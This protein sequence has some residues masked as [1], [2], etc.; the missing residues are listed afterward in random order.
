ML[1]STGRTEVAW[2]CS[3][4]VPQASSVTITALPCLRGSL[5]EAISRMSMLCLA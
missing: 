1:V 4:R 2:S 5:P 3:G